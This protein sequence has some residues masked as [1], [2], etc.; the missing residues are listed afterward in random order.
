MTKERTQE[1]EFI[2]SEIVGPARLLSSYNDLEKV[3]FNDAIQFTYPNELP[4]G[5]IPVFWRPSDMS[6]WQEII[7]Y[8]RENPLGNYGTGLLFPGGVRQD[9]GPRLSESEKAES[10]TNA[11]ENANDTLATITADDLEP[12]NNLSEDQASDAVD[13]DFDVRSPDIFHPSTMG[14]TVCL[15]GD[16]GDLVVSLPVDKLFPWQDENDTPFQVNGR[17][18][19]CEKIVEIEGAQSFTGLAWRRIAATR[20]DTEIKIPVKDFV[21][22]VVR[23]FDVT[24]PEGSPLSLSIQVFPRKI[25]K[26]WIV[27]VV[28]RNSISGNQLNNADLVAHTL[29]Q[30]FFQVK[31]EGAAFSPYPEGVRPFDEMDVDEQALALLYQDCSTWAIGHGCSAGWDSGLGE[32]PEYLY[33]DVMP[34]VELPS[35][36][37]DIE[38]EDGNPLRLSMRELSKLPDYDKKDPAWTSLE[39]LL[40]LY[41]NW[42][43][44]QRNEVSTLDPRFN[45]IAHKNLDACDHC[46]ER[47]ESG[48]GLLKEDGKVRDAFRLANKAM[49]LQQISSKKL[50]KRSLIWDGLRAAPEES[51]IMDCRSP[52][53]GLNKN[54]DSDESG[55]GKWRAFQ[56]AFL[57]MSL[58]GLVKGN[59]S[60][61][62]DIVDLIWFPTGGGKTEAYLSVAAF[63]MFHQRLLMASEDPHINFGRDGTNVFMRYT[64]RMLTTQQFQRAASLICAMEYL[65]TTVTEIE[66]GEKRFSLGLWIGG[67]GS[68]NDCKQAKKEIE[69]FK[70]YSEK[71]NPLVLN[72]CPWCRSEIGIL[73]ERPSRVRPADF[74]NKC[75]AGL[76]TDSKDQPVLKCSDTMC[77]FGSLYGTLPIEVIDERIY[78]DPPSMFIGTVDKFA[79]LAYKPEAGSLF[80]RRH[81]LDGK[82][83]LEKVPPG[84]I[85][86][87]EFHLI[88]G[89]LGTM[90][91]LYEGVIEKLCTIELPNGESLKPKII[92]S[93]ATIRGSEDQVKSIYA[94]NKSQL[95]PSPGLL[96]GDSFFGR[97]AKNR[98]GSG[99][100]S[101]RLYLGIHAS[102][103]GSFQTTQVRVFAAA[104]FCSLFFEGDKRDPWWTLLAF[105]NSLRELSGARTL[106]SSDITSRLRQ[107][108]FRYGLD[109]DKTRYLNSVEELTGRGSQS[110]LVEMMDRLAFDWNKKGSLDAC[111]ASSIIEV[112]VDI[113]RLSLMAVVGQPKSTAQYIQVTGRVGRKWWERPGLIMSMYNPSKSRDLSHFEQFH[114][115]H[116]RLYERVEPTSA[117]PFSVEAVKR[118][119]TGA[120]L[121]W[122]RQFYDAKTPDGRLPDYQQHLTQGCALLKERCESVVKD[123]SEQE[124]VADCI[125]KVCDDLI[126]KWERNPQTWSEY[127]QKSDGEYLILWP[128]QFATESQKKKGVVVPSS[129]RNVDGSAYMQITQHYIKP[130]DE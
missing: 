36:T 93:T 101:G 5:G 130:M 105:Y 56:I 95:F 84:L 53:D 71:G 34:A 29:Y 48:I 107:Y 78:N 64:L 11:D 60:D 35:M 42:V 94:R 79:M 85:I 98:S 128:G 108:S 75:V 8:K 102:N 82:V 92:A 126:Y 7:H 110:Q 121:M 37:P 21:S 40:N 100:D 19:K 22:G 77:H 111:L 30:S 59:A 50:S 47:I 83:A 58:E 32:V 118:A 65:R 39:R 73:K 127:P 12:N 88:S 72:E 18:S 119:M 2:R 27:T 26:Q 28:L 120:L 14:V 24:L 114:S 97:Y 116:R 129:M 38:D 112:G 23:K 10:L 99:L 104:L 49:L 52:I 4:G 6:E 44:A 115:Y 76:S 57:L 1:I 123:K 69:K 33:A 54:I 63:Y 41:G 96:M 74:K 125:Q 51:K 3:K 45:S 55:L 68:P 67:A 117:T 80:G 122:A 109:K 91:G 89:P 61:D 124:R 25:K 90:Y 17:Y 16:D 46:Y 81:S 86:Q 106:F 62:R 9:E 87:D 20:D 103:Y 113:E 31:L 13:D 43:Q 15:E 66:L 70:K